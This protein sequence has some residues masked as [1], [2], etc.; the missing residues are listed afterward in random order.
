MDS[1]V[2]ADYLSLVVDSDDHVHIA[3]QDSFAGDV[4]Y[5]YIPTYTDPA[6]HTSVMVDSYLTVGSKLSLDVPDGT[7]VPYVAYK[8]LGNTAKVAWLANPTPVDGVTNDKFTGKWEVQVIPHRII[9]SDTNRFCIGVG[10]NGQPVIG[11]SNGTPGAK[12]IE[13]LTMLNELLN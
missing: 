6:T 7:S 13:Y 1:N 8:G 2:G 10:D 5:I 9:D 3:Y 4:K 11:F 12:G